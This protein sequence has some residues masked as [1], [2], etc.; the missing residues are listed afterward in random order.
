MQ[1]RQI[2]L[3]VIK[4]AK[5]MQTCESDRA[6]S[7]PKWTF[8][9]DHHSRNTEHMRSPDL[10]HSSNYQETRK[11]KQLVQ[12][13]NAF[14]RFQNREKLIWEPFIVW[15]KLRICGK[16]MASVFWTKSLSVI[17]ITLIILLF[18]SRGCL[19]KSMQLSREAA[20]SI[21]TFYTHL[22]SNQQALGLQKK[23]RQKTHRNVR[24]MFEILIW[25]ERVQNR[26]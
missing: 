26:I 9:T 14:E 25:R 16:W 18:S 3:W 24:Y 10:T 7:C 4:H 20:V 6:S 8:N 5:I 22:S 11:E 13:I 23:G 21:K 12:N 17:C 15:M 1:I 19:G 2:I